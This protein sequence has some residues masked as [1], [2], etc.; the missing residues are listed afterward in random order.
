M[1]AESAFG[2]KNDENKT[3]AIA[4]D[5]SSC[6][7]TIETTKLQQI[8]CAF[9]GTGNVRQ[10]KEIKMSAFNFRKTSARG[11]ASPKYLSTEARIWT[12]LGHKAFAR[13][14]S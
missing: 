11:T 3:A 1:E 12:D 7:S 9:G 6:S 2:E 10:R 4:A 5:F 14:N 13:A 8:W